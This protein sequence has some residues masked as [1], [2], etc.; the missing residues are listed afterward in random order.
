[1]E[2]Y[3]VLY[4]IKWKDNEVGNVITNNKNEYRYIPNID[5]I[6]RLAK[7]GMPCTFVIKPQKE[8]SK[9]LPKFI[10]NRIKLNS[11]EK[12]LVTDYFSI[13]EV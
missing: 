7:Q 4:V 3:Q 10:E 12:R 2:R 11:P 1:M 5:N 13:E 6:K 9:K 8:W